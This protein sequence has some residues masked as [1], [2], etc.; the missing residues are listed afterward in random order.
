MFQLKYFILFSTL[1]L[2]YRMMNYLNGFC[3]T[4]GTLCGPKLNNKIFK[5][6]I[7]H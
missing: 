5:R 3:I 2:D 6:K 1:I 4:P 7:S